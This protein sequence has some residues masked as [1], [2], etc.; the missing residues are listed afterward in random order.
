ME[1]ATTVDD[2]IAMFDGVTKERLEELRSLIS[3]QIPGA[4]E[5]ISY[6]I[7]AYRLKR[8]VVYFAGY[9]SHVSMYP[10]PVGDEKFRK[11]LAPYAS[12]KSTARFPHDKPLPSALIRKI[13]KLLIVR[14]NE[15]G[16]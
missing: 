8:Y 1:K 12:G 6:A 4:E 7:P 15:W 16:K 9:K 2:Y 10:M 11:E 5:R 3:S 13:V 14:S